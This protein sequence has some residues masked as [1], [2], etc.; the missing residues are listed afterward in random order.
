[1]SKLTAM[2][3]L[4]VLSI[5]MALLSADEPA[6]SQEIDFRRDVRPLLS[7]KC[8][9]CHGPDA[10]ERQAD[11]RLDTQEGMLADLGGYRAVVPGALEES[12]VVERITSDDPDQQMP[13][14]DSGKSLSLAEVELIK[15]W[16]AQG[17]EWSDHW[18][19]VVPKRIDPPQ[20]KNGD[21]SMSWIDD[22]V[23]ARLETEGLEPSPEA[24]LVTLIRRLSFDL[25]GLPPKPEEVDR[26]LADDEPAAYENLVNRLLASDRYGERMAAYWLDLV[27]F[28]D[29]VGYHGDQDHHISPYRDYVID[30]FNDNL[31]LD[32]FTREQL[33]GDLLPN[34]SNDEKIASGYNR[35]LQTSHEG[36]VQPKEY[37]AIYAADRVRNVSEVWLGATM[38]CCQCHDHKY[39]P[40]TS[41]DFYSLAAFFADLDEAG[42]F[43]DAGNTLPTKRSPEEKLLTKRERQR[44]LELQ[45]QLVTMEDQLVTHTKDDPE[46]RA[47]LEKKVADLELQVEA[48]RRSARKTMISSAIEPRTMRI[49]PRGNWLDDSGEIVLPAVPEHLGKLEIGDRRATR[50]ELGQ[51]ANRS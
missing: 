9:F 34:A 32:Q 39:D 1:M 45:Q 6:A 51:L 10:E 12:A 42:H 7:D 14:P 40:L 13:P 26:F 35:L 31:P 33:A 43:S 25:T 22:F 27:R 18:A 41:R 24:D 17:A 38:G 48:I 46:T 50:L 5:P 3:L 19:Y 44:I 49:L 15:Q 28:A 4:V 36:G 47:A 29:T 21:W 8:F 37:L 2:T 16:I 23:L 30:A 20:P 11:L